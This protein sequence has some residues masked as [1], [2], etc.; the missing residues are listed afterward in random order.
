MPCKTPPFSLFIFAACARYSGASLLP[1]ATYTV[2][3][4]GLE[5]HI[6]PIGFVHRRHES[7]TAPLP[8]TLFKSNHQQMMSGVPWETSLSTPFGVVL[9]MSFFCIPGALP[10]GALG[11]H[12]SFLGALWPSIG[13]CWASLGPPWGHPRVS[14][15]SLG[16]PW[17]T[18][19]SP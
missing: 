1:S 7:A 9:A 10:A 14:W 17:V 8:R 5:T 3:N 2:E 18:P 12:W 6:L 19:G 16:H 4:E 11:S 15:V 13:R